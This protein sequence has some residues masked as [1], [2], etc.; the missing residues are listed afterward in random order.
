MNYNTT[1]LIRKKN[2]NTLTR[3]NTTDPVRSIDCTVC[4]VLPVKR[5][6]HPNWIVFLLFFIMSYKIIA[7]HFIQI[8]V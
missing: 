1:A 2:N 6:N 7:L 4:E 8:Q 5:F 3:H